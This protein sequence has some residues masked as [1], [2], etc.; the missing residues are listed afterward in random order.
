MD[1]RIRSIGEFFNRRLLTQ[2]VATRSMSA[3]QGIAP[4]LFASWQPELRR[5]LRGLAITALFAQPFSQALATP[6]ISLPYSGVNFGSVNQY[7]VPPANVS[8]QQMTITNNGSE[9]AWATAFS[10]SPSNYSLVSHNC[11]SNLQPG[12]S[13]AATIRFNP[14]GYGNGPVYG[15]VSVTVNGAPYY[16]TAQLSGT[17]GSPPGTLTLTSSSNTTNFGTQ[18]YGS[19]VAQTFTVKNTGST[20]VTAS[21]PASSTTDYVVS[22]TTCSGT[23]SPGGTCDVQV[24]FIPSSTGTLSSTITVPNSGVSGTIAVTGSGAGQPGIVFG[25]GGTTATGGTNVDD[26]NVKHPGL[27]STGENDI[28]LIDPMARNCGPLVITAPNPNT[29]AVNPFLHSIDFQSNAHRPCWGDCTDSAE[30]SM[31]QG[32]DDLMR[33]NQPAPP[34]VCSNDQVYPSDAVLIASAAT[35]ELGSNAS[36]VDLVY[37]ADPVHTGI[38]NKSHAQQDY[39][40]RAG[41]PLAFIRTYQAQAPNSS[42]LIRQKMGPGWYGNWDKTINPGVGNTVRIT[43]GDGRSVMF[44]QQSNGTWSP[45]TSDIVSKLTAIYSG[46]IQIGWTY[47]V[48][49]MVENYNAA[50]RLTSLTLST[51]ESYLLAYDTNRLKTVT[52][53]AG[54]I[55]TFNYDG[56]G[57]LTSLVDPAGTTTTYAYDDSATSPLDRLGRLMSV[58]FP[59]NRA[60]HYKYDL[61]TNKFALTSIATFENGVENTYVTFT[62][63]PAN[64]RALGNSFGASPVETQRSGRAS[65]FYNSDG[66]SVSYDPSRV[67]RDAQGNYNLITAGQY[68]TAATVARTFTTI[69]G[70]VLPTSVTYR[71]ICAG[72]PDVSESFSYNTDGRLITQ[73]DRNGVTTSYT[74]TTDGRGLV[75]ST[76]QASGTSIA[77]TVSTTWHASFPVPTQIVEPTRTTNFTYDGAGHLLTTSAVVPGLPTRTTTNTYNAQGRLASVQGPRT[78]VNDTTTYTY[79]TSGTA[80]GSVS[81]VTNAKGQI[82]SFNS[83]DLHGN[84]TNVTNPDGTT[85]LMSYDARGRL[86]YKSVAGQVVTGNSYSTNG[87]LS[88]V[89]DPYGAVTTYVYDDAQRLVGKNQSNGEHIAYTLDNAGRTIQTQT[90]DALGNLATSSSTV[91]DGLG[92][93][94]QTIDAANKV[95]SYSYD[96]NGNVTTVV[97]PNNFTTTTQYDALNRPILVIDPLSKSVATTYTADGKVA[98]IQDPDNNTTTYTYNGFGEQTVLQSPDTATTTMNYNNGGLVVTKTDGRGKYTNYTYDELG[99]A[100]VYEQHRWRRTSPVIR[101]GDERRGQAGRRNRP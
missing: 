76:T 96:A 33:N 68:P 69:Q 6:S 10:F 18:Q 29:S 94:L 60:R 14:A 38:G 12:A 77:S 101:C 62:Y 90:F 78:D 53:P 57:R 37:A 3:A 39:V 41:F 71:H 24:T 22:S 82:T 63:D 40:A 73:V 50:G 45:P 59:D 16:F 5:L 47:Q 26:K 93:V 84:P 87:L 27:A 55:L 56:T 4:R 13:C 42:A 58:T 92:R 91:Y 61:A 99:T 21:P 67:V 31:N 25:G 79:Y 80:N 85:T 49:G 9:E 51:G 48:K 23:I 1:Y 83:Y 81:Q 35:S 44:T 11:P 28:C 100:H 8:D 54:R 98:S 70:L 2:Y 66:S 72:C 15:T 65:V 97:D 95:T 19:P 86:L 64:G 43:R 17:S 30:D 20:A 34:T 89:S 7:A 75:A 88:S 74:Y 52:D 32:M 46:A 36:V